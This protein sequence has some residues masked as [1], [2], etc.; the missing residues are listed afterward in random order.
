LIDA[1]AYDL[2]NKSILLDDVQKEIAR[3]KDVNAR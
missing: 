2:R 3:F 1:R